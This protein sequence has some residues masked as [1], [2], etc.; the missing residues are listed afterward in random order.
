MHTTH[1]SWAV[2]VGED[3]GGGEAAGRVHSPVTSLRHQIMPTA[4]R[5]LLAC[6]PTPSPLPR[7]TSKATL[8]GSG[9]RRAAR[10][11]RPRQSR[12]GCWH[13]AR[14]ALYF[15]SGRR[16]RQRHQGL[17][18]SARSCNSLFTSRCRADA[19]SQLFTL[20]SDGSMW[21]PPAYP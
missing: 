17:E 3:D 11:T 8:W 5:R 15:C 1:A 18:L 10:R 4:A 6:S 12:G 14:H 20:Y 2:T 13:A 19:L 9:I 7:T 16:P 21:D